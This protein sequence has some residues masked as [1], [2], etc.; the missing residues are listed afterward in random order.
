[1]TEP[2]GGAPPPS[3]KIADRTFGEAELACGRHLFAQPCRF[4]RAVAKLDQLPADR[5]D[6]VAFAGRSNVGKSSLVNALTGRHTLAR[7]SN[8]PGRTQ[9]LI[10]FDLGGRLT[11]V[12]LPGYG[13]AEAPK[14]LVAGWQ[15]L[16]TRYLKGRAGLRRALVLIDARHGP[17]PNDLEMMGQLDRAAVPYQ[18]ILTKCDKV[19]AGGLEAVRAAT[20]AALRK[21]TAAFP[22]A[23]PTSARDGAG[24]PELRADLA[25]L[26]SS[27]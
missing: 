15:G 2:T 21:R 25:G 9:Q 17:K 8:T 26:A 4:V 14:A 5:G 3:T 6:E 11:L 12:D 23:H 1:M 20:E 10:F 16:L 18:V 7:T 24:I 27:G 19:K 13:Y 22:R